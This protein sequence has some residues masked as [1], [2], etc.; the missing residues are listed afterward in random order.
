ML[1]FTQFIPGPDWNFSISAYYTPFTLHILQN[2]GTYITG[3]NNNSAKKV[4][5]SSGFPFH[6]PEVWF[7][8]PA[9]FS[10]FFQSD[11]TH[12][13]SQPSGKKRKKSSEMFRLCNIRNAVH[14]KIK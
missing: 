11:L 14:A 3:T 5:L 2:I 8:S 10:S 6:F 13:E 9:R 4:P 12:L 7:H 1:H